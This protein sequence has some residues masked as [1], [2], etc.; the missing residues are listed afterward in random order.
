MPLPTTPPAGATLPGPHPEAPRPGVVMPEHYGECFGCGLQRPGGLRLR[1][2]VGEGVSLTAQF[3]VTEDHQGAPGLAHGGVLTSAL[4]EAQGYLMWLLH[5]PAVTGRLE[6]DFRRP[7]PVGSTLHIDARLT[8]V[9]GRRLYAAADG[10]IGS[11]DGPLA[12]TST[13]LFVEVPVS[14]FLKGGPAG[15]QGIDPAG[16]YNP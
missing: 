11:P 14:H 2:T 13:A 4:D 8:G 1:A 6:T 9:L 5:T 12:L 3:D 16:S 10:R 15:E 7:V